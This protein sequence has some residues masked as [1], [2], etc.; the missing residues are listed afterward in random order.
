[1]C[2]NDSN[3]SQLSFQRLYR[4]MKEREEIRDLE[5]HTEFPGERIW[6]KG[7]VKLQTGFQRQR[8]D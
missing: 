7:E 6:R 1:M 2:I 5:T 8:F 3:K 4:I